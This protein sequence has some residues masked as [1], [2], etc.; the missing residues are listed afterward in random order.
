M[1]ITQ[2]PRRRSACE[3][4]AM[5]TS[6]PLRRP[7]TRSKVPGILVM[8]AMNGVCDICRRHRSQGNHTTCSSQRQ[9]RYRHLW[10]AEA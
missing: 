8:R 1:P 2:A 9:A 4:M 10:E 7:F 6:T 3:G 5:Q